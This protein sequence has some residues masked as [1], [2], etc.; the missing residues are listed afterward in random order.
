[1]FPFDPSKQPLY[2][3]YVRA[4]ETGDHNGI[5]HDQLLG[6]VQQFMQNAPP[7]MQQQVVAQYL[8]QLSPEQRQQFVQQMGPGAVESNNPQQVGQQPGLLQ[9]IL[10]MASGRSSGAPGQGGAMGGILSNPAAKAA[11]VG[12]AGMAAKHLLG[13]GQ[14]AGLGGGLFGGGQQGY[15]GGWEGVGNERYEGGSDR[16]RDDRAGGA[17]FDDASGTEFVGGDIGDGGDSGGAD[18]GSDS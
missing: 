12:V 4:H 9:K 3:Q 8:Q 13:G 17:G 5:A 18:S 16:D 7:E 10:G 1:M 15:G 11:L 14:G 2:E 6:H